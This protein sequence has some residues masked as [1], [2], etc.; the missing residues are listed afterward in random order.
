M[1]MLPGIAVGQKPS[2][3]A[4]VSDSVAG[5]I[6]HDGALLSV[7][8]GGALATGGAVVAG[9][10]MGN[11]V[12]GFEAGLGRESAYTPSLFPTVVNVY[13]IPLVSPLMVHEPAV[14]VTVHVAPPGDAVIRKERGEGDPGFATVIVALSIPASTVGALGVLTATTLFRTVCGPND[15]ASAPVGL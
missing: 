10:A 9:G 13:D 3:N 7:V 8:T 5:S 6:S 11:T 4:S 14:P 1:M 15:A 2:V 12:T